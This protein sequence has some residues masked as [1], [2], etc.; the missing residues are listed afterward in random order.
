MEIPG[1]EQVYFCNECKV[2]VIVMKYC[3]ISSKRP[4][5]KP[6]RGLNFAI[7]SAAPVR[8]LIHVQI[9]TLTQYALCKKITGMIKKS[10]VR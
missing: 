2:G 9:L 7:Y 5:V 3:R 6:I 4:P 1:K 10:F 8:V